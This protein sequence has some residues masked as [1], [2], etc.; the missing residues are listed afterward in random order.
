MPTNFMINRLTYDQFMTYD[1]ILFEYLPYSFIMLIELIDY[2]LKLNSNPQVILNH[3]IIL[4]HSFNHI[5]SFN[6]STNQLIY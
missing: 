3:S 5:K 4:I 1:L 6:Q 2:Y